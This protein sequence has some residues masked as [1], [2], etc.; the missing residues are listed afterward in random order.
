MIIKNEEDNKNKLINESDLI[1]KKILKY[2]KEICKFETNLNKL[3]E[4]KNL[5]S[6][7]LINSNEKLANIKQSY[8]EINLNL[9][10]LESK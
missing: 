4:N 3:I 7:E 10:D 5:N 8:Q 1:G 6:N 9:I 2:K